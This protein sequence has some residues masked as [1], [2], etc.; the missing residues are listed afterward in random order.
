MVN[1]E[2]KEPDN[3]PTVVVVVADDDGAA[4]AAA[5]VVAGAAVDNKNGDPAAAAQQQEKEKG[6]AAATAAAAAVGAAAAE[7]SSIT[8]TTATAS[9]EIQPKNKAGGGAG[10]LKSMIDR[11]SSTPLLDD[12]PE[13]DGGG[14]VLLLD[15]AAAAAARGGGGE[16]QR[17]HGGRKQRGHSSTSAAVLTESERAYLEGILKSGDAES[18][19]AASNRLSDRTLFPE[20]TDYYGND[21]NGGEE[22]GVDGGDRGDDDDVV[23]AVVTKRRDSKVQ[24][25]LFRL[26]ET[27]AVQPSRVLK[28][29]A[30]VQ[31]RNSILEG[32]SDN[33]S[34][35]RLSAASAMLMV[36][37]SQNSL[38]S[39][40]PVP[41]RDEGELE[42]GG[43]DV[44]AGP[45]ADWNP[46]KDITSWLDGS[47]GVEVN[48]SGVPQE[49]EDGEGESGGAAAAGGA[50]KRAAS[51]AKAPFK[52]LG[53]SAD[54][55]SCHPHVL[56]PPLCESLL[57]FV[58]ESL[59]DSNFWLKYSLVRDGGNLYNMLRQIR[60]S[61][62]CFLAIE[63]TEGNVFGSF[64][65]QAWR[66]SQG[67]Y[68][69]NDSFLWK[70]RHS[71]LETKQLTLVQQICQESEIQVYPF[72]TGNVAVQYC[73]KDCLMMGR[74]ELLPSTK[75]GD[76]LGH[77]LYLESN[78]LRGT[79]SNSETF[80]NPCL[81]DS[82]K[83]GSRF[84]VSNIEVWTLTPHET[85]AEAE[86][87]ELST[88]F[89]EGRGS[90]KS[91]NILNILVGGTI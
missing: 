6:V 52:I 55:I 1:D 2:K 58:P 49:D 62:S 28:A 78:L 12:D 90:E 84:E 22:G 10:L 51:A 83:R 48:D 32:S 82:D 14:N 89:L 44:G 15:A 17:R 30:M 75:D 76:H 53:T 56:S 86:R 5:V 74:G 63:T 38:V 60:A 88:L 43:D 64:T 26:H 80:G 13:Y 85:V 24:Q 9:T 73:S 46:F 31:R 4:A 67:W 50:G 11:F 29:M 77:A 25:E 34:D 39:F 66:H 61:N 87:S 23:V 68:G 18:I 54:D 72:R 45:V 57:A 37:E 81:V 70:M 27:K 69:S 16:G 47:E 79:T 21:G 7:A 42:G 33:L 41:E 3:D 59:T 91:L 19:Q 40:G 65:S 8:T 71:R 36:D 20:P 35:R